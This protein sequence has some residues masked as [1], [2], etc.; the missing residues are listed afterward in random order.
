MKLV[1]P[2]T[3]QLVLLGAFLDRDAL[4]LHKVIVADIGRKFQEAIYQKNPPEFFVEL[5][6]KAPDPLSFTGFMLAL[7]SCIR[8]L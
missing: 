3:P 7:I 1:P 2:L 4:T 5:K 8:S 6:C